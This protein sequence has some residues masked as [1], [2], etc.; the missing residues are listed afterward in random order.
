MLHNR[1]EVYAAKYTITLFVHQ[2]SDGKVIEPG[3]ALNPVAEQRAD[4][5]KLEKSQG[6]SGA[7]YQLSL[8]ADSGQ[9]YR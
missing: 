4:V 9:Q 8:A 3:D 2:F 5:D 7:T 6:T 1:K